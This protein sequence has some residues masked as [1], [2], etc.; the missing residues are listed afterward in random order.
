MTRCLL[1]WLPCTISRLS[2]MSKQV[3]SLLRRRVHVHVHS[4]ADSATLPFYFRSSLRVEPTLPFSFGTVNQRSP[5]SADPVADTG[6]LDWHAVSS[7]HSNKQ[8]QAFKARRFVQTPPKRELQAACSKDS[9]SEAEKMRLSEECRAEKL[10]RGLTEQERKRQD[11]SKKR[12]N[13]KENYYI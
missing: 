13:A 12:T 5:P 11:R 10:H 1:S 4:V 9:C 3:N 8:P 2:R 7:D 6:L